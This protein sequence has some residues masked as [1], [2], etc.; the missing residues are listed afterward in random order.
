M[1]K[2]K[3][4]VFLLESLFK[5]SKK[6]LLGKQVLVN[7]EDVF[8]L[9]Q[10]LSDAVNEF[11]QELSESKVNQIH[12]NDIG[13]S[14]DNAQ[15]MM[16]DTR[17]EMYRLKKDANDYADGVLSRLQLSVTKL[18]QN[19]IKMEKNITEGRKLIQQQQVDQMRGEIDEA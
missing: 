6:Q 19:V 13:F 5:S 9:L 1:E 18:Q 4:V 10:K 17:K 12:A 3:G 7:P 2:I 16:V 11:E 14:T 8:S 15:S